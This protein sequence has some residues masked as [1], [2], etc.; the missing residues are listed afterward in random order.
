MSSAP[1][2][3]SA[4]PDRRGPERPLPPSA[5]R[6]VPFGKFLPR[7]DPVPLGHGK[8]W[9]G[10]CGSSPLGSLGFQVAAASLRS[11]RLPAPGVPPGA[12]QT[13]GVAG[14]R[15][16]SPRPLGSRSGCLPRPA[17]PQ[18][19]RA[20]PQSA[21]RLDDRPVHPRGLSQGWGRPAP[22]TSSSQPL[23]R[24]RRCAARAATPPPRPGAS[25]EPVL[26]AEG[27]RCPS[28]PSPSGK[29]AG[30]ERGWRGRKGV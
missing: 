17:P 5:K 15:D 21:A 20:R 24:S 16:G 12:A 19:P 22:G 4:Q 14:P 10:L 26:G 6:Y 29:P 23:P 25:P 13:R 1:Q 18:Q 8:L 3:G 7:S 28:R 2:S 27:G 9:G 11:P 30:P